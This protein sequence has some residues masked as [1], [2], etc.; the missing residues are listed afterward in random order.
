MSKKKPQEFYSTIDEI[1][2]KEAFLESVQEGFKEV[3]R[4]GGWGCKDRPLEWFGAFGE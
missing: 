4:S 2:D 1:A 3:E